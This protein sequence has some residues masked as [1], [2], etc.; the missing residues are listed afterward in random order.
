MEYFTERQIHPRVRQI[1]DHDVYMFLIEGDKE[2]ALIDTGYGIDNIREYISQ[3]T[4]KPIKVLLTHNHGDHA[5]GSGWF[6]TV[7]LND[8]DLPGFWNNNHR[9]KR[10]ERM[11]TH[12]GFE[13]YSLEDY[14]PDFTGTILPL[15]QGDVI[16]LG[17]I[18]LE[19]IEVPGHSFGSVMFLMREERI[20]I[21]GDACGR[22]LGLLSPGH[23]VSDYLK[24]LENLKQFDGTYDVIWRSHNELV[25]PLEVLDDCIE[26]CREILNHT[27]DHVPVLRHGRPVFAA[28]DI[29][30]SDRYEKRLDGRTGNI[31]YVDENAR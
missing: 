16:D 23:Y 15:N 9:E 26:C 4:D 6:D 5:S 31:Y 28:K 12:E 20:I 14:A 7:Y 29:D 3:F 22:R 2:A 10:Y 30:R 17:R 24:A 19:V 27:D 25:C 8:K 11:H 21:Y 18:T 1:I 13:Q